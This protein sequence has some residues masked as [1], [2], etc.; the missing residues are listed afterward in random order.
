MTELDRAIDLIKAGDKSEGGRI[1]SGVV[2]LEPDNESAWVWLSTCVD[3]IE[4]K[5]Y[6]LNQIL[7][8]NPNNSYAKNSLDQI[9][10]NSTASQT[11]ENQTKRKCPYCAELVS[12]EA[13]VCRFCGREISPAALKS[14]QVQGRVAATK[15]I[16]GAIGQ[17]SCLLLI[18]AVV[19]PIGIIVVGAMFTK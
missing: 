8:I 5:K 14:A 15:Q 4:K 6:C 10:T 9:D 19:I 7:R 13:L 12:A 18:L 1:L 11:L 16:S 2:K 3:P 17:L